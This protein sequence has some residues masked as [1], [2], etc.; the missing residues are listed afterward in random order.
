MKVHS[1]GKDAK[2]RSVYLK[3]TPEQKAL[4]EK[5]AVEHGVMNPI[6]Q[7]ENDFLPW[8]MH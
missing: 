3:T 4:V 1:E 2:Q 7:I 6:R 8:L 5:R